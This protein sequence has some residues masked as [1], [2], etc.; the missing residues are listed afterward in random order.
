[1]HW[2]YEGWS[3]WNWA[4]MTVGMLAFWGLVAWAFV[5][6]VVSPDRSVGEARRTP[7]EVLAARFAAGEI[8]NAEY[9]ERLDT[10][11]SSATSS[12]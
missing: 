4:L 8:D 5:R 6:L 9:H 7:E 3:W 12:R 1:M 10:L 2:Y 11:R